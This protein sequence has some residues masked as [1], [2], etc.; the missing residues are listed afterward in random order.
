MVLFC[1][2]LSQ[3]RTSQHRASQ[4]SVLSHAAHKNRSLIRSIRGGETRIERNVS[5]LSNSRAV[6]RR[7]ITM[8]NQK[9]K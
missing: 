4:L 2:P 7:K 3:A 9:T 1:S 8:G 5:N 6:T